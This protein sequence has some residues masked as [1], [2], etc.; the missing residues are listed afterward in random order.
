MS[1]LHADSSPQFNAWLTQLRPFGLTKNED[2]KRT[3]AQ[4]GMQVHD[5]TLGDPKE[6][7]AR[8]I[9]DALQKNISAVSQYPQNKGSLELRSACA[10]WAKRRFHVELNVE[11]QL[12]SSNG[13]KEAVFHIPHVLL[14]SGSS[15]RIV[16]C[17]EPGYP[18]Y[19]AGTT[20]AGGV[21]YEIPLLQEHDYVFQPSSIPQELLPHI[22][23]IW[24][25][26]PHNPTGAFISREQMVDI[27]EWAL[28]QNIVVLSDECYV[29][30]FFA[31]S[32]PPHSFLE[33]AAQNNYKNTLCFFSLSKR[34][35]MTGYRS[36]FVAGD[37]QII[38]QF[39]KYR[40]NVG[41]G[42][43]DFIQQAAV[44]AW[45]DDTHVL[46]RNAIFA[47]KR[48]IADAF[49]Q[50]NNIAVLPSQATLYVWGTAPQSYGDGTEF[51]TR[52]LET[53]GIMLTPGHVFGHAFAHNFRMAL[54][55]TATEL[56][57]CFQIWQ[58]A[59]HKGTFK[60]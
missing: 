23:A 5:F 29:D 52:L 39:E 42:T 45:S 22:A 21:P 46:E 57:T 7:T 15:K 34:S 27:Y 38:S 31:G 28:K 6:P 2:V 26:Y 58:D 12:I 36:G 4:K 33:I 35:G 32:K 56:Q 3:L 14:N 41:V 60:L 30:M 40:L 47:Q 18:V 50:K 19:R 53:T 43:P 1:P 9:I 54:V 51:C 48:K 17:P 13:S 44:C 10:K 20:L 11:T 55:P 16:I 25:C 8:I 49:L 59:I 37:A 24:L